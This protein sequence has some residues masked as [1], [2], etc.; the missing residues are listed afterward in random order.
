MSLLK[1]GGSAS[2][3]RQKPISERRDQKDALDVAGSRAAPTPINKFDKKASP[4]KE[5]DYDDD[6]GSNDQIDEMLPEEAP[7]EPKLDDEFGGS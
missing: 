3:G 5:D 7:E 2:A 1:Q 4:E 6:F